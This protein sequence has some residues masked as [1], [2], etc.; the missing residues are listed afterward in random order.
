[1]QAINDLPKVKS[2]YAARRIASLRQAATVN[3]S[4]VIGQTI[5]AARFVGATDLWLERGCAPHLSFIL[6]PA[7]AR[8]P[9]GWMHP[10]SL[11]LFRDFI[12]QTWSLRFR[13]NLKNQRQRFYLFR[14]TEN[15]E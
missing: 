1:M 2:R 6:S 11:F 7:A 13:P 12:S 8:L 3:P 9:D 5:A 15:F 4:I 14:L 10:A